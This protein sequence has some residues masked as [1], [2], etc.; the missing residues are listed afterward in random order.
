MSQENV[1]I[2]ERLF[3]EYWAKDDESV[4][5]AYVAQ[6]HINHTLGVQGPEGYKEFMKPFRVGLPDFHFE[7][8]FN[9]SDGDYVVSVWTGVGTHTGKFMGVPA[10]GKTVRFNGACIARFEKGIVVEE[11]SYPDLMGLMQQIAPTPQ[12]EA[13]A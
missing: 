4:L 12:A 5:E 3:D 7:I 8:H 1:K 11:W 6:N 2:Y 13:V 10:T 9:L